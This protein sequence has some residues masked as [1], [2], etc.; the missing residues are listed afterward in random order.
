MAALSNAGRPDLRGYIGATGS[1]KGVSIR[2]HLGAERPARL[3][4]W[5]PLNEHAA[6]AKATSKVAQLV[7]ACAKAGKG[8]PLAVRYVPP[9]GTKL[10]PAF[11]VFCQ[12]AFRLGNCTVLIEELSDVTSPSWAPRA[13]SQV[14]KAGRHA[15]LKV[16]VSTQRPAQS[17][18]DFLGNTTY[19]RC[20][21]LRYP[22]DRQAM[23]DLMGVPR[24]AI[25]ALATI[26]GPKAT[27]IGYIERDFRAG[28]PAKSD[29]KTLAR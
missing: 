4:V 3:M 21:T 11:D 20:F 17:D 6:V 15:S 2:E 26:E 12:L 14:C 10:G 23:A 25:E 18:K 27:R 13:W 19:I 7:A 24:A 28:T 29:V 8:G 16:V 22:T 5:D 1:G 9:N